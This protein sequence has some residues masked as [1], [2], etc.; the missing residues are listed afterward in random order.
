MREVS[1]WASMPRCQRLGVAGTGAAGTGA[2]T[3]TGFVGTGTSSAA[4]AAP[5]GRDHLHRPTQGAGS[6]LNQAIGTASAAMEQER[7][8][9]AGSGLDQGSA[10][11]IKRPIEG[12]AA[13]GDDHQGG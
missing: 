12:S 1:S 9:P 6:L 13:T 5:F 10:N 11:S 4:V 2:G 3:A 7:N 8:G